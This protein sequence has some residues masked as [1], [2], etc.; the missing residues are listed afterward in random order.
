VPAWKFTD[1]V[2]FTFPAGATLAAGGFALVLPQ[3]TSEFDSFAAFAADFRGTNNV[4]A[5]V[6]IYGPYDGAL[7]NGGEAVE[8]SRPGK[9]ELDGTLPDV[10]ID[11]VRYNDKSPW[12]VEPDGSGP[13]L[14]RFESAA[15][16][17]D[18]VNWL[19][20]GPADSNSGTPGR[21]NSTFDVS[22]PSAPTDIRTSV[23]SDSRIDVSWRPASDPHSGISAYKVY[24]NGEVIGQTPAVS[25]SFSDTDVVGSTIYTYQIAALNGNQI[26]GPLSSPAVAAV[27]TLSSTE[28]PSVTQVRVGFS[29]ELNQASAEVASKYQIAGP[30]NV[31]ILSARLDSQDPSGSTV[32]LTTTPLR[33]QSAYQLTVTGVVALGGNT[34]SQTPQVIA[35]DIP[36]HTPPRITEVQI[37]GSAWS[38]DFLAHLDASGLGSGGLTIPGGPQQLTT[39]PWSGVDRIIVHFSENVAIESGDLRLFGVNVPRYEIAGFQYNAASFTATWTLKSSLRADK[40]LLDLSDRVHDNGDNPIDGNWQN[41][42][43]TFPSGNGM[44]NANDDFRFQINVLPGD[45]AAGGLVDRGDLV[46]MIHALGGSTTRGPYDPRLD[47]NTDGQVDLADLRAAL[48]RQGSALPTGQPTI[49]SSTPAIAT[50][51]V[52]NRLGA[53]PAPQA[54]LTSNP[55]GVLVQRF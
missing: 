36:D 15:Y 12:P 1:G 3:P 34:M 39:I 46:D 54:A 9:V 17:N 22:P 6:T 4:P 51:V 53:A 18:V 38:A 13:S 16:G 41:G 19:P 20:S 42:A 28:V 24:R 5:G 50:D 8:L 11:R 37:A 21:T 55:T 29:E 23:I 44:M 45:G 40:L 25:T 43:S 27:L 10:Q 30:T 32:I 49:R 2:A 48:L 52:F 35:L 31:T 7:N 14:A 47:L 26:E 33:E